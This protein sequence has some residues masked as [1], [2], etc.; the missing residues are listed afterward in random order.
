MAPLQETPI[1]LAPVSSDGLTAQGEGTTLLQHQGPSDDGIIEAPSLIKSGGT[2]FLFF[3][4]GCFT[5][6]NYAVS[7]ATASSLQGPYSRASQ[8]LIQS[9]TDLS[10]PG[11]ADVTRDGKQ[12]VFH[13]N[14]ANGRAMR[15]AYIGIS[16]TAVSVL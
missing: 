11:G 9:G 13:A 15:I 5:T 6:D 10:G 16:G 2:Y 7:Y 12:L 8:A 3:S 1:I 4:P 14:N